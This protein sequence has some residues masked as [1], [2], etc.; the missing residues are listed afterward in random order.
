MA[1]KNTID[2]CLL[3]SISSVEEFLKIQFLGSS[4]SK[5][6]KYFNKYETIGVYN[7]II[8]GDVNKIYITEPEPGFLQAWKKIVSFIL[9]AVLYSG[10][11]S[12]CRC[13]GRNL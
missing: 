11:C 13:C 10:C 3:E 12:I 2:Y 4:S 6:K 8:P 5:L 7:K 1:P 9:L